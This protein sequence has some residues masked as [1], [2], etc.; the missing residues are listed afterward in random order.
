M[1]LPIFV[2]FSVLRHNLSG[3]HCWISKWNGNHNRKFLSSLVLYVIVYWL[4]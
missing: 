3:N 1:R 4:W 2:K